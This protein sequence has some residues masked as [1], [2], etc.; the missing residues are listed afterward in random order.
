MLT[1][2]AV[3]DAA[4]RFRLEGLPPESRVSLGMVDEAYARFP[5]DAHG[6]TGAP[7]SVAEV[8]AIR[9]WAAARITG[10]VTQ[11]GRPV[12]G[13][14]ITA[15]R[16][17]GS[18]REAELGFGFAVSHKDGRYIM[19]DLAPSTVNVAA[20]LPETQG[21]EMTARAHEGVKVAEGST[22][23]DIDFELVPGTIAEGTVTLPDG[24]PL[25]GTDV[26]IY[27]PAHP[28]S[29]AWVGVALTDER[30]RY[31]L[32][33]PAGAQRVYLMD[34]RYESEQRRV[35]TTADAP[36]RVDFRAK[37]KVGKP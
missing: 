18:M 33:V 27:G 28:E 26:G 8:D 3:T 16:Q 13:A 20:D 12:G 1:L 5:H 7:G 9:L 23:W 17:N 10:R 34:S 19:S 22:V 2:R 32:R 15:H 37:M 6:M 30:G 29:S 36:T 21:N 24:K 25:A 31:R 14:I 11:N 4:G 35:T